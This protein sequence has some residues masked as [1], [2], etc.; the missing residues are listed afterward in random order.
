VN[1]S[2]TTER[3]TTTT[4]NAPKVPPSSVTP[5]APPKRRGRPPNPGPKAPKTTR[6][7]A[8]LR[9]SPE[10]KKK[11][12]VVLEVLGGLRSP[13]SGALALG[14]SVQRYYLIEVRALQ[15]LL[16]ALDAKPK[17]GGQPSPETTLRRVLAERERLER[18]LL[19]AQALLRVAQRT[20]GLPPP[21]PQTKHGKTGKRKTRTP[22]IR[23]RRA[24]VELRA[25]A[26][27]AGE[28]SP[29]P[30]PHALTPDPDAAG[31]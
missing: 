30:T 8:A 5:A 19:R 27:N 10:A 15:G 12:S 23:A 16:S 1:R 4:T 11:A 26:A 28:A 2:V 14:V 7:G 25:A 3:T 18:E 13:T 22:T 21:E 9:G 17:P 20:V 24:V 29:T 6:P 31:M